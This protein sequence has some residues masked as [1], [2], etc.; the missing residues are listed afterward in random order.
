MT[1]LQI[2]STFKRSS[3]LEQLIERQFQKLKR[4]CQDI[5]HARIFLKKERNA[6][7]SDVVEI[8]L[9]VEGQK[10]IRVRVEDTLF[11]KSVK[12]AFKVAARQL[13]K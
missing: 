10:G 12:N 2:Q 5:G 9:S 11:E 1:Q 8:N 4:F 3:N 7:F 13:K 6:H